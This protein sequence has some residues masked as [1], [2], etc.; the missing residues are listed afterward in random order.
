MPSVWVGVSDTDNGVGRMEHS[1]DRET[2]TPIPSVGD[3]G[4]LGPAARL[5]LPAPRAQGG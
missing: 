4:L 2:L 1:T 5:R 3:T